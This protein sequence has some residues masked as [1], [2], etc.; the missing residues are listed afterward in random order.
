MRDS[1]PVTLYYSTADGQLV[2][3]AVPMQK[4]SDGFRHAAV[5]PAGSGGLRQD[6][7]Y[8]VT[9]GDARSKRYH[10]EVRP[11]PTIAVERVEY[12]Y[13]KYTGLEPFVSKHGDLKAIEGTRATLHA[14]SNQKI[15]AAWIDLD[16]KGTRNRRLTSNEREATLRL[17][18]KLA[19]GGQ[20][21][22]F[23]S[24]QLRFTNEEGH[25]NPQPIRH[26]VEVVRDQPPEI[27]LV[28]P[29]SAADGSAGQRPPGLEGAGEGRRFRALARRG[30]GGARRSQRRRAVAEALLSKPHEGEFEG[31][32]VFDP[33][34]L[35]LK[36]G[37]S[38]R[39]W[40]EA[41]D[42][43]Q[44][45]DD[46]LARAE[47]ERDGK[48]PDHDRRA[49]EAAAA[50][51]RCGEQRPAA[52][53]AERCRA[54][55]PSGRMVSNSSRA[56]PSRVSRMRSRSPASSSNRNRAKASKASRTSSSRA[57]AARRGRLSPR[58][59]RAARARGASRASRMRRD[60][61]R[62]IAAS[63]Q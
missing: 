7:D 17:A 35:K 32:Y 12:V 49:G 63:T 1:D 61:A 14:V 25:E 8:Y 6:V 33:A 42:N 16:C 60:A 39:Y 18:L 46:R 38:I 44:P 53:A 11:A 40:A 57:R 28:E 34:K 41:R 19:A 59:I 56:S 3:Q 15:A 47:S 5:L 9:A 62:R 37:D 26:G 36:A 52:Q 27:K 2:D 31:T 22:E 55:S 50:R 30:R 13:P 43:R 4:P 58:T 20:T 21:P 54:S 23:T 48:V 24:Y 29:R 45:D 10:V 51:E